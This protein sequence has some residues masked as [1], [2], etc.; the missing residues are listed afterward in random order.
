MK[1]IRRVVLPEFAR[2]AS[3]AAVTRAVAAAAR[4]GA[5]H[6]RHQMIHQAMKSIYLSRR[7]RRQRPAKPEYAMTGIV[8]GMVIGW[9]VGFGLELVYRKH[10]TLMMVTAIVGLSLGAGF[11]AI[12]LWWR[13]CRFRAVNESRPRPLL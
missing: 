4:F 9:I 8:V 5:S 12:R 11:E 2:P 10:M 3:V 13:M 7:K 1:A 6:T